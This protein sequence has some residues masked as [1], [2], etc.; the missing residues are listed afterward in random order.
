MCDI[1]KRFI[2]MTNIVFLLA[3]IT[4]ISFLF[5]N[6]LNPSTPSVRQENKK[7]KDIEFPIVF[8]FCFN[9]YA[10]NRYEKYGYSYDQRLF[11][12][13][14]AYNKTLLGWNGHTADGST[15]YNYVC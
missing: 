3:F 4:H 9:D 7:L 11:R 12:G 13:R 14:S 10:A 1:R 15:F 2:I 8:N 6:M 5:Y